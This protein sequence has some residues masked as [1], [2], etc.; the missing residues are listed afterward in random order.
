MFFDNY[1]AI[2]YDFTAR[3]DQAPF[4]E[5]VLDVTHRVNLKIS[6]AD[7][8]QMTMVYQIIGNQLPEHIAVK[9]YNNHRFAWTIFYVNGMTDLT[10]YWPLTDVELNAYVI[11]KYG[12]SHINDIHHYEKLPENVRMDQQFII[13]TYGINAVNPVTNMDYETQ[14]NDRKRLIYVIKPEWITPFVAAYMK[15]V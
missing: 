2:Q 4:K 15:K 13:D 3:T 5:I 9:L 6:E 12:A 1:K 11:K 10:T 8:K 14:V 7:F